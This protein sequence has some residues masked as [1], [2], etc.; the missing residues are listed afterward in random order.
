M[1]QGLGWRQGIDIVGERRY[2]YEEA[3]SGCGYNYKLTISF[4]IYAYGIT[5]MVA[6][7]VTIKKLLV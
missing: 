3:S 4:T 1:G 2:N 6:C 7:L 5:L